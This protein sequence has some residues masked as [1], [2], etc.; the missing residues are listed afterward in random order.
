MIDFC[1]EY[2]Q[3]PEEERIS[4]TNRVTK[5]IEG[6][7]LVN[8]PATSVYLATAEGRLCLLKIIANGVIENGN[9]T[10]LNIID[11][12]ENQA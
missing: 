2:K 3:L 4:L 8:Y 5:T 6:L 11:D 10:I 9:Q 12:I 1:N 7:N